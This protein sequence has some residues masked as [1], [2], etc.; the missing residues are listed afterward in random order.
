MPIAP[1][2]TAEPEIVKQS[3]PIENTTT[4]QTENSSTKASNE[5]DASGV[6]R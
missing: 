4:K 1:P 3:L 5:D 6:P 2:T